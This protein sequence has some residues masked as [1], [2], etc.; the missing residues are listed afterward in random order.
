[1]KALEVAAM[2]PGDTFITVRTA[3]IS[4]PEE[5]RTLVFVRYWKIDVEGRPVEIMQPTTENFAATL[6][7]T[8]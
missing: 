6:G 7:L 4:T 1:M 5:K 3:H 2:E 8:S